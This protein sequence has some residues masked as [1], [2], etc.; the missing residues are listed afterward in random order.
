[1][2]LVIA[3]PAIRYQANED[4]RPTLTVLDRLMNLRPSKANPSFV[5]QGGR[6]LEGLSFQ[7]TVRELDGST[8]LSANEQITYPGRAATAVNRVRT[9]SQNRNSVE[10]LIKTSKAGRWLFHMRPLVFVCNC[11]SGAEIRAQHAASC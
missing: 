3:V 5:L 9:K 7:D 4:V 1:M 2:N 8:W 6:S 11:S 10:I